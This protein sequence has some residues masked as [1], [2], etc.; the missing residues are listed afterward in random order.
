MAPGHVPETVAGT[1]LVQFSPADELL[2]TE[3]AIAR[4][5]QDS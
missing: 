1:E 3:A 4:A 5:L 2:A